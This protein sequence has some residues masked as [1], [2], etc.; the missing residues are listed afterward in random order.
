MKKLVIIL[1]SGTICLLGVTSA[2]AVKYNEAPM[3]R[4]KVAAGEIPPV[5]QR[6][7]KEPLVV[8][9]V[10]EI[11]Q[12]GGTW[13][14]LHMEPSMGWWKQINWANNGLVHLTRDISKREP[15]LATGWEFNEDGTV[16]TI[17]LREG[18]KWSDGYPLTVD[19]I[20]FWW[21]DLCLDEKYPTSV[22]GWMRGAEKELPEV[23]KIDDYTIEFTYSAPNTLL[24]YQ[25]VNMFRS[26]EYIRPKHHLEKFHPK[27]NPEVK[28]VN[29][30]VRMCDNPHQFPDYPVFTPWKTILYKPGKRMLAERNPYYWKVDTEGNQ[31]PYIDRVESTRV[32]DKEMM[33]FKIMGGEVDAQFRE[34]VVRDI[35]LLKENEERGN[36]RIIPWHRGE[37]G[38]PMWLLNWTHKNPDMRK[39]MEDQKFRAALSLAI[40]RVKQNEIIWLGFGKAK[41]GTMSDISPYFTTT[42]RGQRIYKKWASLYAEHKPERAKELLNE[43]GVVDIDGDG[44]REMP[45]GKPLKILI[46]VHSSNPTDVDCTAMVKE[47]WEKIGIR[48]VVNS[49]SD[50]NYSVR[51]SGGDY[52]V[53]IGRAHV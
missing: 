27:Y 7:P 18:V 52:D 9:P 21:E 25:F 32:E 45:N 44:F 28:D 39:L 35:P 53:K 40:D 23:R 46:D 19:D 13:H 2:L 6:L 49:V 1:L 50:A 14:R 11:G 43:T 24:P 30:L 33:L 36:Y 4:A 38:N 3:L 37:G 26:M 48:T 47:D 10:E 20:L 41:Q 42:E 15:N 16:C 22:P 17:Y 5:E 31:L 34:F 8:E 29:E 12:Y 51:F